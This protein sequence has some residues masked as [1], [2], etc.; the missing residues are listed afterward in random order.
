MFGLRRKYGM[1][2]WKSNTPNK[3]QPGGEP[4]PPIPIDYS[5]PVDGLYPEPP[6]DNPDPNYDYGVWDQRTG[7]YDITDTERGRD[8]RRLESG[9][10]KGGY[11]ASG[12][13]LKTGGQTG[14]K[15]L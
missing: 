13:I 11:V 9:Y 4:G 7:T 5:V 3:L 6:R 2:K 12:K 10:K 1:K 8:H 14:R 15:L